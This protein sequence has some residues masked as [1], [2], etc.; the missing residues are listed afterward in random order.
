VNK[1]DKPT[2][3]ADGLAFVEAPRW[4]DGMLWFSDFYTH[5]VNCVDRGGRLSKVVDVP[6]QPSGLGWLPDGRL[7]VVS[8]TD[9]RLLRMDAGTLTEVADLSP[10][11]PFHCND[12]VVDRQG[13]AYIGNFGF[14]LVGRAPVVP[15]VL[16]MV[17]PDGKARVVADNLLFP[18][19]CVITPDGKTLIVAETFGK[20]LTAFTISDDGSLTGRRVWADLGDASPDGI[21]LDAEGAV[22]VASPTTAEFIRVREHGEITDRIAAENQAIACALGGAD[23]RTLYMVTGRVSKP[24]KSLAE[25]NGRITALQVSVPGAGLP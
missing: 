14:D 16:I 7:L 20:R 1:T 6:G 22:W 5:R 24:E 21:C 23:R 3:I 15:T 4:H 12:M 11:A 10:L 2:V 8:M 25:R 19:G 17:T 13:R 9:R 18:N